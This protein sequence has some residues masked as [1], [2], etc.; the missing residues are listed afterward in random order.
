M[1]GMQAL[2]LKNKID[3]SKTED[4]IIGTRK[5]EDGKEIDVVCTISMLKPDVYNKIVSDNSKIKTNGEVMLNNYKINLE[6]I[7]HGCQ[8]PNFRDVAWLNELGVGTNVGDGI[9]SVLID[10]EIRE[11]ANAIITFSGL[12]NKEFNEIYEDAKNS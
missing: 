3:Y 9:V 4:V 6:V 5:D 12:G 7:R 2:L 1:V 8:N 10:K 11:L